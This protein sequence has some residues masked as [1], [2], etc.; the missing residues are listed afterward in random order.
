MLSV[1]KLPG[2]NN[3][4]TLRPILVG[5]A[6]ALSVSSANAQLDS[7]RLVKLEIHSQVLRDALNDWAQQTGF[8]LI[9]PSSETMQRSVAP[10]ITGNFSPRAALEQL[11][12]GTAFTYELLDARTVVIRERTKPAAATGWQQIA[13]NA[14][15]TPSNSGAR[16]RQ[17]VRTSGRDDAGWELEE[18]IVTAQR[19]EQSVQE[20]PMSIIAV[21]SEDLEIAR[22]ED[23]LDLSFA[24]PGFT[25]A[26]G[27]GA[28]RRQFIVR[29]VSGDRGN[30]SLTGVYLDEMP[31][32]GARAQ[33][34]LDLRT[35][36]LERVEVLKG[37]QGTLFG[38]G[39]VGGTVRLMTKD[40]ELQEFGGYV[41][42][43]FYTTSDGDWSQ[44]ITGVLNLP[45]AEDTFGL[46]I[47][48]TYEDVSG[49]IDQPS[50][51]KEN[52]NSN[53]GYDVRVKSL[54]KP[55][56]NLAVRAM[57]VAHDNDGDGLD[58]VN[59]NPRDESNFLQAVDRNAPTDFS[60]EFQLY[61]L[62]V[63]Y[64]FG[65][66]E[67]LSSTSYNETED[68]VSYTQVLGTLPTPQLEILAR[69]AGNSQLSSQ[70]IRLTSSGDGPLN[71]TIGGLYKNA[72]SVTHQVVD[73]NL[74]GVSLVRNSGLG[75]LPRNDSESWAAY[76]NV[77]YK[78]WDRLELGA[79]MRYFHDERTTVD[80]TLPGS[81]RTGDFE[82]PSYRG[83]V[84]FAITD[85][86]NVYASAADG[87]RSGGFNGPNEVRRGAPGSYGS[88]FVK[89]YEAG[90]KGLLAGG[91]FSFDMALF[92]SE[93]EDMQADITTLSPVDG[94]PL[95]FTSNAQTAE[96]DGVELALFWAALD[97]L[98]FEL[99][100]TYIDSEY[101]KVTN[102]SPFLV[103]DPL[104]YVPEY[105]VAASSTYRFN[106]TSSIAGFARVDFNRQGESL[107]ASTRG[108]G[109]R[110]AYAEP[111]NFVN[112]S[113][114]AEFGD[115]KFVLFARNLGDEDGAIRPGRTGVT[116]QARPRTIG[117]AI[118]MSF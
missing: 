93:Y 76:A 27:Y 21:S 77:S 94:T 80:P 70:E 3:M 59:Q 61:N 91:R 56:E 23:M 97:S 47:A 105:S 78:F 74:N 43:S 18:V 109:L 10:P 22:V 102:L 2:T 92:K 82:E 108:L 38:E 112:A 96:N 1:A 46:R 101:T 60:D 35:T 62:S 95:Q 98:Q 7:K 13:A 6:L 52:I 110:R 81:L 12:A 44:E 19:R 116:P 31:V 79:G 36:D 67:L 72:K 118:T 51:G 14:A 33:N 73:A 42:P 29:G 39:S 15:E 88:E 66:A 4:N 114:G 50:I 103:G 48:G 111:V 90:V 37:P 16:R 85:S 32:T 28:G 26:S 64:D 107:S 113:V 84:A 65:F 100:G 30:S 24:V 57:V 40:P 87:F 89:S 5:V 58:V 8:Q 54:W 34:Y 49:W 25:V 17:A 68:R 9:T 99:S 20:V 106:M 117:A 75:R 41:T 83:Y 53:E 45:V 11:L 69:P 63:T 86:I 115:W 71:W 104:D 55:S